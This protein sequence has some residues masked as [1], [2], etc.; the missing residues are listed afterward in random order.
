MFRFSWRRLVLVTATTCALTSSACTSIRSIIYDAPPCGG[1]RVKTKLKGIPTTLDVP[2]HVKMTVIEKHYYTD[3]KGTP[4][5]MAPSRTMEYELVTMKELYTVDFKRPMAGIMDL[6]IVFQDN[7]Q[8]FQS[9]QEDVTDVTIE[10]ISGLIQNILSSSPTWAALGRG[11]PAGE[12]PQ[13][14]GGLFMVPRVV[15][16]EFIDIHSPNLEGR[17]QEFLE[18]NINNCTEVCP[19]PAPSCPTVPQT[20]Q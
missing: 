3:E 18:K 7:K 19:S 13:P 14:P 16:C 11:K 8:Y 6:K 20:P 5:C 9:I 4:L 10:K 17:L 15:A 12:P 2:T 1:D